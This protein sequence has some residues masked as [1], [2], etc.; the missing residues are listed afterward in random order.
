MIPRTWQLTTV[1]NA[2]P[3]TKPHSVTSMGT[4]HPWFIVTQA[5]ETLI[6]VKQMSFRSSGGSLYYIVPKASR[7]AWQTAHRE[8]AYLWLL[9]ATLSCGV[10]SK[11]D[12]H[13]ASE[14][15]GGLFLPHYMKTCLSSAWNGSST[16]E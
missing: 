11:A 13:V 2:V 5:G 12:C 14:T 8:V 6:Y 7:T 3:G 4:R 15:F 16:F 1:C 10:S 9:G